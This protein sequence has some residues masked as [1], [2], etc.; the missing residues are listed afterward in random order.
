M[1]VRVYPADDR[2]MFG[3]GPE[4][5]VASRRGAGVA[6]RSYTGQGG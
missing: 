2:T 4:L 5:V 1:A 3:D 6:G